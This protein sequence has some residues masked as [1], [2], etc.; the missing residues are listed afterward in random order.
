MAT[1]PA[2]M[3]VTKESPE[4]ALMAI[5]KFPWGT[6]LG[7]KEDASPISGMTQRA[8]MRKN[9]RP[10]DTLQVP[11]RDQRDRPSKLSSLH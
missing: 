9:S 4:Q 6:F 5:H 7:P 10:G 8:R 1:P 3:C 2:C 11:G